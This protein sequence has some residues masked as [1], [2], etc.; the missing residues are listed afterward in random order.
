M[1]MPPKDIER[2]ALFMKL[3]SATRPHVI[4][5]FPRNGP[6]GE[7]IAQIAMVVLTQDE[8]IG[9]AAEAERVTRKLLAS[10]LPKKEDAQLG[11]N[12]VYQ[13]NSA[14]QVLFRACK[15]AE[16][17]KVPAFK[18]PNEISSQLTN[19]EI[20]VL[21][22]HYLTVQQ[23]LGPIVAS[24]SEEE[25]ES[26]VTAL[27]EGGSAVPLDLLSWGALT[28]LVCTLARQL[29]KL[30]TDSSSLGSLPDAHAPSE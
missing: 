9:A 24:M 18:T 29:H 6:D 12:D 7:P 21:M 10:D 14:V 13:N 19:D 27:V 3:S 5:D 11:Y 1:A 15:S 20:G 8:L 23:E 25:F 28:T 17:V 22:H 4:V 26:W 2:S 16:D 30:R